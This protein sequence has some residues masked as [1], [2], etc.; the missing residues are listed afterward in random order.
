[1]RTRTA[2]RAAGV[3]LAL[4][5]LGA[6][7]AVGKAADGTPKPPD[8][9]AA[10]VLAAAQDHLGEP[11]VYGAT[12]PARWD[13]S[14]LTST[15][16]RGA[17]GV[18]TIPRTSREQQ[19]WAWPVRAQD[20]LPGD[21]VF[22]GDPVT[23]VGLYEGAGRILDASSSRH[24]VVERA[25]W[26]DPTIRYGRVPR[27]GVPHPA[28]PPPV[29]PP[30]AAPKPEPTPAPKP[31]PQ[32]KPG[33]PAKPAP[34]T[35]PAPPLRPIPL[36]GH[37]PKTPTTTQMK[38]FVAALRTRIGSGWAAG[39]TGPRY[40]AAGLVDWAWARA[41][42]G[43]LPATPRGI[44]RRTTPVALRDLAVGDLIFWGDPAVHVAVYV[45]NGEM[46]D[47]SRVLKVVSQRLVFASETVRFARLAPP[48]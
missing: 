4:A 40:D 30:A 48:R 46:I 42:Y 11:Y 44:E 15:L 8:A 38:A 37:H 6:T 32:P 12:G 36:P 14:G 21:L 45:G 24:A 2:Y 3:V 29:P 17:G 5:A 33:K 41:G 31:Q 20:A 7:T 34:K 43:T 47:A 18:D 19:A 39:G 25:I 16:W 28:P 23:H 35:A 22:F 1:L 10:K 9:R 26:T 27:A 13:C